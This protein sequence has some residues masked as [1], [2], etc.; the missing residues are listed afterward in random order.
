MIRK[1]RRA[2][3]ITQSELAERLGVERS[4][5]SK[6]EKGI[7]VPRGKT[8]IAL[9]DVLEC[10]I[11]ELMRDCEVESGQKNTAEAV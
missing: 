8:L 4:T 1:L 9:A 3:D 7:S 11:D 2:K 5:V 10:S 6:W